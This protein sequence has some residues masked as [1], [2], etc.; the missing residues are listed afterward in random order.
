[1]VTCFASIRG[2]ARASACTVNGL[3]QRYC[4]FEVLGAGHADVE[5]EQA[6][7]TRSSAVAVLTRQAA[8]S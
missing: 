6:R 2:C 7:S 4:G 1:M 5:I 3:D 8:F